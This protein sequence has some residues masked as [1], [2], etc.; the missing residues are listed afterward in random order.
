VDQTKNNKGETTMAIK[1][2]TTK[3]SART[4]GVKV[5]VYGKSGSGKTRLCATAP[6]PIILSA[7]AGLLSLRDHAIPVIEINSIDDLD[8]AYKWL[9][10]NSKAKK[11]ETVCLDS[12]SEIGEIV[13]SAAKAT[14]KD[15]RQ[16][17][18]ELIDHMLKTIKLFRDLQGKNVYF[19]A[20][21]T[22]LVD[23][24]TDT[25]TFQPNMPGAKLG[26]E[27]PYYF[28]EVFNLGLGITDDGKEYRFLRTASNFQYEAKDR[29]GVLDKKEKP[30]LTAIFNKINGNSGPKTKSER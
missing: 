7:E 4:N 23:S 28:D 20:K 21:E 14:H 6:K 8:A 16:A 29:S 5:L 25:V 24:I 9:I 27:L 10:T 13:L 3:E 1:F 2:T 30:D 22:K 12:I 15:A 26:A 11:F 18:G 17:Y 19:S